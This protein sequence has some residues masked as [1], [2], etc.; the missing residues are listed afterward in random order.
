[1]HAL[2]GLRTVPNA[3]TGRWQ[4]RAGVG[5]TCVGEER[6]PPRTGGHCGHSGAPGQMNPLLLRCEGQYFFQK[7]HGSH[8]TH[9]HTNNRILGTGLSPKS[10]GLTGGTSLTFQWL[11]LCAST[12]GSTSSI[13]GWGTK[14]L[15]PHGP[16]KPRKFLELNL[17]NENTKYQ[18]I[19]II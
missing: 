18:L 12:A 1:M 4:S 8:N 9:T 13:P 2:W 14:I 10:R 6:G 16:K 15:L 3:G 5:V 19:K 11:R 7:E 17:K